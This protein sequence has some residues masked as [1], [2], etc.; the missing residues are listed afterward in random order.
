MGIRLGKI[1]GFIRT[2]LNLGWPDEGSRQLVHELLLFIK[3][4]ILSCQA[5]T[6]LARDLFPA[7][8]FQRQ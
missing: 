5:L 7:M 1:L 4:D 3:P 6:A 2:F 8:H